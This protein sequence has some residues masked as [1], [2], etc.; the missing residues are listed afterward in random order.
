MPGATIGHRAVVL[1]A[2]LHYFVGTPILKIIEI[3]AVISHCRGQFFFKLTAGGLMN[4]W[5]RLAS[6]LKSWYDEI[7]QMVK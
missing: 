2:F 3:F 7:G 1:S 4:C 5:H 6:V